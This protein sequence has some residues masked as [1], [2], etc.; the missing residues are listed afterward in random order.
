MKHQIIKPEFYSLTTEKDVYKLLKEFNIK[1]QIFTH[2]SAHRV[3]DA[4][5]IT[6]HIPG[7]GVKTLLLR[8]KN[9]ETYLIIAR[10]EVRLAINK[11]CKSLNSD[12][13]SFCSTETVLSYCKVPVGSVNPLCILN[14]VKEKTT[15]VI[16]EKLFDCG[17]I[18]IHPMRNDKTITLN[19]SK[20]WSIFNSLDI[21]INWCI[22]D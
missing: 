6:R 22:I 19:S 4:E 20:L 8:N 12:R 10:Q 3:L 15:L 18:A 7:V 14:A 13:L 16:D 5:R 17:I 21:F 9:D 2:E 11:I 1:Y